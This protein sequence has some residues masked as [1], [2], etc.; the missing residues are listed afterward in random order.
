VGRAFLETIR[1]RCR[2]MR[3]S[4]SCSYRPSIYVPDYL[5][6]VAER[7]NEPFRRT[8][9]VIAVT[10]SSSEGAKFN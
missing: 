9:M 10:H 7:L 4:R 3:D 8:V 1:P 5:N 2:A 6:V